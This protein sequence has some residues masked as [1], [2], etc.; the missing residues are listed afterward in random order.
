MT[1]KTIDDEYIKI[2]SQKTQVTYINFLSYFSVPNSRVKLCPH[3]LIQC[4]RFTESFTH[5]FFYAFKRTFRD[6][7]VRYIKIG[8]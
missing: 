7:S 1:R 4:L 3:I 5:F 2:I 8:R 6:D